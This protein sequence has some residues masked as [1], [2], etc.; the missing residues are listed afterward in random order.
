MITPI[1]CETDLNNHS[2]VAYIVVSATG[3]RKLLGG[4]TILSLL[5]DC[6][7]DCLGVSTLSKIMLTRGQAQQLADD[8][9]FLLG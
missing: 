9:N 3:R 2:G 5:V 1:P 8:I 7:T 6:G 4:P